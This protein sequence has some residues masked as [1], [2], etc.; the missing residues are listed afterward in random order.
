MVKP[1]N[2]AND[3]GHGTDFLLANKS[4]ITSL[5]PFNYIRRKPEDEKAGV[6]IRRRQPSVNRPAASGRQMKPGC[7]SPPQSVR[8]SNYNLISC[9]G[10]SF[11]AYNKPNKFRM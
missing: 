7:K 11:G 10:S 9:R 5:F 6:L 2:D 4:P 3:E 1:A 8:I